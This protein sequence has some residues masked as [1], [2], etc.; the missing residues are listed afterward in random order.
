[1]ISSLFLG[2]THY[3]KVALVVIDSLDVIPPSCGQLRLTEVT[4]FIC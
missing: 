3:E 1:M 2:G 4:T